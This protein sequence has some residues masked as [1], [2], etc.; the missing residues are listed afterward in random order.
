[1]KN[2]KLTSLICG[3]ALSLATSSLIAQQNSTSPSPGSPSSQTHQQPSEQGS[4][5]SGQGTTGA[6]SA[7]GLS[8]ASSSDLRSG[9]LG[10]TMPRASSLSS[11]NHVR[12]SQIINNAVRAQDGKTLG[13]VRDLTVDAESGSI[14]YAILSLAGAGAGAIPE[15]PATAR[16]TVPSNRSSNLGSGTT[17]ASMAMGKLVPV[18]WQ[19]FS[20]SPSSPGTAASSVSGQST[21]ALSTAGSPNL[22]LNVDESKLR[23]APSFEPTSWTDLQNGTLAQRVQTHFGLDQSAVGTSGSTLRGQGTSGTSTQPGS[24]ATSGSPD[25]SRSHD[26]V[27]NSPDT[28]PKR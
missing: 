27:P 2:L 24:S 5:I 1:M 18:P 11:E 7:R 23:T 9:A 4:S 26:R 16:E 17:P 19:L 15:S 10:G 28:T 20:K 8:G 25:S 6:A 22:V 14:Q 21:P 12:I 3:S 13:F